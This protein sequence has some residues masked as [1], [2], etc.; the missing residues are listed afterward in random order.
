[1]VR[2]V[3][4]GMYTFMTVFG[5]AAGFGIAGAIQDKMIAKHGKVPWWFR[6]FFL[7]LGGVFIYLALQTFGDDRPAWAVAS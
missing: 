3:L 6:A 2:V 1:M 7:A 4:G 5:A